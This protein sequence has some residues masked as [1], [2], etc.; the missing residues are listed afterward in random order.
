MA[1]VLACGPKA[2]LSHR[3]AAALWGISHD[4]STKTDVSLPSRS[5]R[6]RSGVE[7][8]AAASL[9]EADVTTREGIPCTTVARTL[10]D[11]AAVTHTREVERAVNEAEVL[12]LFDRRA[13]E[14]A[15]GRAN[16]VPG[17]PVVGAILEKWSGPTLTASELEER[18]LAL[19]RTAD[20]EAPEVN[21]WLPL[22]EGAVKVDFLWRAKRLIVE[23]DGRGAHGTGAAF[24][25]DRE[26]DQRLMLAGYR[27]VRFTWRQIAEERERVA[28]TVRGLL[29]R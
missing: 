7:V 6:K 4:G 14:D 27:V 25:R 10:I 9:T 2:V 13:T 26:R 23:T 18:F 11:L 8:H 24:E 20:A 17:A 28:S 1:A 16:E 22:E 15:L 21:P 19:C 5:V 29:A 3:S 12:R